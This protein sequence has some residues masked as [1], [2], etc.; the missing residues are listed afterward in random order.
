MRHLVL[1]CLESGQAGLEHIVRLG[2]SGNSEM[3]LL[4]MLM[5]TSDLVVLMRGASLE[6]VIVSSGEETLS[7]MARSPRWPSWRA[8]PFWMYLAKPAFST[9][10]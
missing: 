7:L 6:T 5:P 10:N 2:A 3:R 9:A 1:V 4:S 8:M